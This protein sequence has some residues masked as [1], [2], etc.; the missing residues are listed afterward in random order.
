[1]VNVI[2]AELLKLK[3]KKLLLITAVALLLYLLCIL[4]TIVEVEGVRDFRSFLI[5][6][7]VLILF[8]HAIAIGILGITIFSNEYISNTMGQLVVAATSMFRLFVAKLLV[9]LIFS[10]VL[11]LGVVIEIAVCGVVLGYQEVTIFNILLTLSFYMQSALTLVLGLLPVIFIGIMCKRNTI[12]PIASLFL[13]LMITLLSSMGI[14]RIESDLMAYIYPF[15]GTIILQRDF[16][17]YALP[18]GFTGWVVPT[19]NMLLCILCLVA[20][21]ILFS[22]FSLYFLKKKSY[23]LPCGIIKKPL[24]GQLI[25]YAI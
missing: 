3:R 10:V 25:Y 8:V 18:A 11:M 14:V 5:N 17:Y 2:A 23:K 15:G 4:G 7:Y 9:L 16:L 12:L 19:T 21:S 24:F 1:M 6:P 13:Y 22:V 20:F